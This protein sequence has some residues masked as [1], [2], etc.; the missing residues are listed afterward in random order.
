MAEVRAALQQGT[1]K[2][3]AKQP[4]IAVL[5]FANLSAD[6][7]NE[8]V[9][10]GLA[11]EI[12]NVLSRV[13]GLSVAARTSSFSFKG[14][15]IETSE[16][17][18]RLSVANILEG[19]VRRSGNRIR[20]TVQLVDARKGFQIWSERYDRQMEDIFDAQDEIAAAIA[21]RLQVTLGVGVK[22][23]TKNIEAYELYLKGRYH[24]HQRSPAAVRQA[25]QCF[26]QTIELDPQYALAYAGLADCY[27]ILSAYGWVSA[28]AGRA[29]AQAAVARAMALAP[30]LSEVNLS[31]A[32]FAFYFERQWR[33]AGRSSRE[34]SPSIPAPPAHWR[35]TGCS[36][37]PKDTPGMRSN[38]RPRHVRSI[39]CPH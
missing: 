16:I 5:P 27:G 33:G 14:K 15:A 31:R 9:S 32:F 17:A 18:A 13:E 25:I 10:D 35:I 36:W 3:V 22:P 19:G 20:V 2:P 38:T 7:E 30:E 12:L 11:E 24:W 1:A 26:Q 21:G 37:P 23:S 28:E 29:P 34:Q 6:N 39:R 4:S 8:Y